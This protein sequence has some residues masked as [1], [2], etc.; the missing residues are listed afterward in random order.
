MTRKEKAASGGISTGDGGG[1]QTVLPGF[2]LSAHDFITAFE[3]AQGSIAAML[4]RSRESA[5]TTAQ[6]CRITGRKPREITRAICFERRAGAPI[7]S[8]PAAGFWLAGD[9]KEA[10]A[11]AAA[12]HRRAAQIHKT[13]R[14][15]ERCVKGGD[16]DE[17]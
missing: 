5:L 17:R 13:A 16:N 2:E 11:C 10:R 6:L 7:L 4:P 15:L 9:T 1:Q 8:D 12:L 3:P 14:A